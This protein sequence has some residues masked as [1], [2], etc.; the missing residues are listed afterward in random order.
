M[1]RSW[2]WLPTTFSNRASVSDPSPF[3]RESAVLVVALRSGGGMRVKIVE[4]MLWGIPIVTTS[5]G[6]EGIDVVHGKHVLIADD[7]TQFA[8]LIARVLSEPDLAARLAEESR[9]L[10]EER[11]SWQTAYRQLDTVYAK[12]V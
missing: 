7:P 1:S 2:N 6:C 11:Y 8:D 5:I 12:S 3:L 9:R 10:V 4:A